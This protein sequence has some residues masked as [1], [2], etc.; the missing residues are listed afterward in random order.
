MNYTV[1]PKTIKDFKTGASKPVDIYV[2][3][4]ILL[5]SDR[6]SHISHITEEKLA[7]LTG[8]DSRTVRRAIKRLKDAGHIRVNTRTVDGFKKRNSYFIKPEVQNFFLLDNRF[9]GKRY[10]PKIAGF[11]LLL[12]SVGLNNTH[13]ILWSRSQIAREIGISRNTLADYIT[14]CKNLGLIKEIAN[15]YEITEDCFIN[16][17]VKDTAHAIFNEIC[18]FCRAK[19]VHPPRWSEKAMNIIL[20]KY[21]TPNLSY[22]DPLSIVYVLNNKCKTLPSKVTLP[23]LIKALG[24]NKP[25]EIDNTSKST[26]QENFD[27]N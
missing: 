17:A 4:T 13:T 26:L 12:K 2:W 8:I 15:G 6:S 16:P 19:G 14:Q 20:T 23:Y 18:G 7:K 10:D 3:A 24:L 5:C 11:L 9:F 1:I 27:F 22:D 21:N 25:K